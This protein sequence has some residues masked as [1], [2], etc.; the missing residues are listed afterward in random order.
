M[1]SQPPFKNRYH[2]RHT[3]QEKPCYICMKGTR[4]VLITPDSKDWFYA[5]KGHLTDRN[6][7]SPVV[8]TEEEARIAKEKEIAK[9]KKEWEEKQATKAKAK[10]ETSQGTAQDSTNKNNS[11]EKVEEKCDE[12]S[13]EDKIKEHRVY[14]LHREV[15]GM[16]TNRI[17][18]AQHARKV[19]EAYKSLNSLPSAPKHKPGE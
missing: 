4:V 10:A 2:L 18:Q 16:R 13:K 5:C 6:F 19:Q 1:A 15:Y 17:K 9:I 11:E 3:A 7:A 14:I 12:M 8:D